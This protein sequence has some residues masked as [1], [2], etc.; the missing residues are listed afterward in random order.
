MTV[1]RLPS[2]LHD[3]SVRTPIRLAL[4]QIDPCVGDLD[5]NAELILDSAARAVAAGAD[6]VVFPEMALTGYPIED[7]ALR[8][9]FRQASR[10]R[11]D[12]LAGE[13][14]ERGCGNALVVVGYIDEVPSHEAARHTAGT[15]DSAAV[16]HGGEVVARNHKHHL[17]NYGVFDEKRWFAPGTETTVIRWRGVDFGIVV[18]EDIWQPGGPGHR[19]V[20]PGGRAAGAQRLAV[21]AGQGRRAGSG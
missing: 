6:V 2:V 14:A 13:L 17:P 8:P 19:A 20:R 11:L 9:A 7:L 18:C 1:R 21:R 5:G 12:E 16:I 15:R 4:G 10:R 3:R